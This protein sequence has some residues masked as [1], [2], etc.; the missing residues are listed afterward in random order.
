MSFDHLIQQLNRRT[1][2]QSTCRE[3]TRVSSGLS[4]TERMRIYLREF[5]P[6]TAANL[7]MEA[8]VPSSALVGALLK[9]DLAMGR[10]V[11]DGSR[12][13]WNS[14]WD[15]QTNNDIRKAKA[16]LMRHGFTVRKEA[17]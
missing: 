6:A 12:Y 10:V 3:P 16:L 14:E 5:G 2:M 15:E 11:R 1:R 8:D 17:A 9:A 4:K 13:A 7:A